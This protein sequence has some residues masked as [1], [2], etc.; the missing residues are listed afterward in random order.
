[1]KHV[2][3]VEKNNAYFILVDP[4]LNKTAD[5]H[6]KVRPRTDGALALLQ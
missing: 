6:I 2:Q 3:E 1:M 5:L 4:Y